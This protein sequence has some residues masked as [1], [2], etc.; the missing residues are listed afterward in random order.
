[1]IK[2][3]SLHVLLFTHIR[4]HT[5]VQGFEIAETVWW[6]NWLILAAAER[7]IVLLKYVC[8]DSHSVGG[9]DFF[10]KEYRTKFWEPGSM[11][12]P[13]I[14]IFS[15]EI[16]Q[17]LKEEF[18]SFRQCVKVVSGLRF[19]SFRW[20]DFYILPCDKSWQYVWQ[21]RKYCCFTCK[22]LCVCTHKFIVEKK[23]IKAIVM[24]IAIRFLKCFSLLHSGSLLIQE[25]DTLI[26]SENMPVII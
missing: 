22:L 26:H 21:K 4:Q 23:S 9:L 15:C 8:M 17:N 20:L 1:M 6:G 13:Y 5:M 18:G 11:W 25:M 10:L 14:K 12:R 2:T 24:E 3:D 7:I 19:V 16:S